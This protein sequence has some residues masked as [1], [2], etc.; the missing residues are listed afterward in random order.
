MSSARRKWIAGLYWIG[1]A[2][3]VASIALVLAGHT[4]RFGEIER[5]NFP[6]SGAFAA[7][8]VVAFLAVELCHSIASSPGTEKE[9]KAPPGVK[10]GVS[11]DPADTATA[12]AGD[13]ARSY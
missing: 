3:A 1:T 8:A 6:L 12:S 5:M 10:T 9:T 13:I 7:V 4:A 11:A 2:M